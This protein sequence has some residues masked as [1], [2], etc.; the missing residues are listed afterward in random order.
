MVSGAYVIRGMI[1]FHVTDGLMINDWNL[2]Y[3]GSRY[4]GP[5]PLDSRR[6]LRRTDDVKWLLKDDLLRII[7]IERLR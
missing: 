6:L 3:C 7:I 4:Y 5:L 2:F 1:S